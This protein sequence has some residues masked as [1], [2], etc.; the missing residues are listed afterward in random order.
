MK[1]EKIKKILERSGEPRFRYNQIIQAI[2]K[3]KI[4]DWNEIT[5]LS[6]DLRTKLADE[7]QILPFRAEKV[8][9]SN[10]KKS[11]KALIKFPDDICVETVIMEMRDKEWTA[12]LSSQAGCPIGC[13]FCAT[14]RLD[15]SR[16]LASEEI[17]DQV[18]FWEN[19]LKNSNSGKLT[20]IVL[21]GMGEPFLNWPN[22]KEA[23][24]LLTSEEYFGFGDRSISIST[25]G[26][27]GAMD[28]LAR[29]FPQINLAFSLH[30]A[31]NKVR[32]ELV[33]MNNS[34]NLQEIKDDLDKYVAKTNRKVLLEYVM[35]NEVNDSPEDA[36][37]L[38]DFVKTFQAPFLFHINLIAYNQ[39]AGGYKPPA[40]GKMNEFK[41]ILERSKVSITI[42]KSFGSDI[43]AA[44]GQLARKKNK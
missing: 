11:Y 19:Y 1:Q 30:S 27:P 32:S 14:G 17:S 18:L 21:M 43:S 5:T 40:T 7:I 10:D 35:I 31:N 9:R 36:E 33:P 42:R 26:I 25:V 15:F 12:C 44:C 20:N 34:Y 22:V 38:A 23:L 37:Q 29:E 13:S 4:I 24:H 16:N 41:K 8:E 28:K 2:Y 3:N 6:K 39:A